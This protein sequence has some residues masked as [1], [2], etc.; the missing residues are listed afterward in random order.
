MPMLEMQNDPMAGQDHDLLI[1]VTMATICTEMIAEEDMVENTPANVLT[2]LG[3]GAVD[4][5]RPEAAVV[6]DHLSGVGMTSQKQF[7]S[8][9]AWLA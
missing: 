1:E 2:L 8:N 5:F 3:P 9:P 6:S 7:R 4:P